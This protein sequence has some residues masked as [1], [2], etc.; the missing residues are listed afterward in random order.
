MYASDMVQF[1]YII[2]NLTANKYCNNHIVRSHWLIGAYYT[3]I[4]S[5]DQ[6]LTHAIYDELVVISLGD[7]TDKQKPH[8]FG[9]FG[10]LFDFT[11]RAILT[12]IYA[13]YC[14][15]DGYKLPHAS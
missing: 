14:D 12:W 6:H 1:F 10:L 8:W 2:K 9:C 4:K 15:L 13:S 11:E 3:L 7:M 5:M